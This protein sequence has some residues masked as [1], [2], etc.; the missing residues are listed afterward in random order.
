VLDP[1]PQFRLDANL[2]AATLIGV[3]LSPLTVESGASLLISLYW[4]MDAP[5]PVRVE[6]RLGDQ[7]LEQHEIGL[8]LLP[9][10][11][12]EVGLPEG[13]VIRE[14]YGLVIPSNTSYGEQ[15]LSLNLVT[16]GEGGKQEIFLEKI[17]VI[18]EMET[19]QRWLQIA[20]LAHPAPSSPPD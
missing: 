1:H 13:T 3:D 19:V 4:R 20:H 8:G 5:R 18:D 7:V 16:G 15:S 12:T 10:Y 14:Q 2:G 9:R 11:A 6:T 17:T